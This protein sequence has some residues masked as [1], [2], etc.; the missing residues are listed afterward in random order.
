MKTWS[1]NNHNSHNDHNDEDPGAEPRALMTLRVS[2]D[3]GRTWSPETVVREGDPV[4]I[5]DNPVRFPDCECTRCRGG[6]THPA[7]SLRPAV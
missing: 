4:V 3:S 5:L 2:R 1:L 7:R 6:R